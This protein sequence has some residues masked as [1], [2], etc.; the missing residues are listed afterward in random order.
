MSFMFNGNQLI[1]E[2][3]Q[4]NTDMKLDENKFIYVQF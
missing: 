3:F 2:S 4:I 1:I